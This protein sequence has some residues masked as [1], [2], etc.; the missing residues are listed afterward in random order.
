MFCFLQANGHVL[1]TETQDSQTQEV[2]D[3]ETALDSAGKY[4][5]VTTTRD[6]HVPL[7]D[8]PTFYPLFK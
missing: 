4:L 3:Y 1:S 6:G 5:M 2:A 8:L 7:L